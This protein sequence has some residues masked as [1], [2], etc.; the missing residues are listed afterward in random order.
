M[1]QLLYNRGI[2]NYTDAEVFLN[3]N[4]RLMDDPFLLADMEKAVARIRKAIL[5][6]EHM[7]V[8]G[9]FDTDGLTATALLVEG[10]QALG[11][12]V[13]PYIP[14]RFNEG[15]GLNSSALKKLLC[16]GIT[17]VIA[18]D[19]GT[20]SVEEI[21][22]AKEIG[23]DIIVAD[24]HSVPA[25]LP[26]AIAIINPKRLDSS[27][28]FRELSGVGVAFKL[29]QSLLQVIPAM[30]GFSLEGLFD[31]L[32][33]GTVADVVPLLGENRYFVNQGLKLLNSA[34]RL[35][36]RK[37]IEIASLRSGAL[38]ASSIGFALSPRL[39]AAGRLGDAMLSYNLLVSQNPEEA[40]DLARQLERKNTERQRLTDL[41]LTRAKEKIST[42]DLGLPLLMVGDADFP[43]G[44][45]GIV[46]GKLAEE[47]YRPVVM[48]EVGAKTS[49]GS[50]RSIPEFDMISAIS[51]CDELLLQYGG[52]SQAAGFTV[53]NSNLDLLRQQL[54]KI[55][56]LQLCDLELCP[57]L[58]IDVEIPLAHLNG[59]IYT[60][61]QRLAPF[62]YDNP[63]PVFLS[64]NVRVIDYK[65][66]GADGDHLTLKLQ[67]ERI[68]WR[69]IAFGLGKLF[70]EVPPLIDILY[71]FGIDNW[72]GEKTLR[73]NI[74]DFVPSH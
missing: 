57:T 74:L 62:G 20:R 18:A 7:A 3:I 6:Q 16:K 36:I 4:E 5:S 10:L 37:M 43:A 2:D 69:A 65:Y 71:T 56:Q 34:P 50:A 67:A 60:Q 13:S 66:I 14:H 52:H 32:A 40:F 9:D 23:L 21:T 28:P 58:D 44:V 73:L 49:R 68:S 47:L 45:I 35:G 70:G 8:Y 41:V 53:P 72:G 42:S 39:N 26:P 31:L 27:Y 11:G 29:L 22:R 30:P 54:H 25:D 12:K 55:A 48:L 33:L 24:H 63:E 15:Y 51:Q 61:I 64:R 38:D 19:C 17:L 1:G 59:S 46:A